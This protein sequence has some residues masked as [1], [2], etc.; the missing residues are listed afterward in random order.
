MKHPFRFEID[1]LVRIINF[2]GIRALSFPLLKASS[3]VPDME[4]MIGKITHRNYNLR[5]DGSDQNCYDVVL[6][7]NNVGSSGPCFIEVGEMIC[8]NELEKINGIEVA[9]W[10]ARHRKSCRGSY[11]KCRTQT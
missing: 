2:S 1:D 3:I 10:W 9:Y 5:D 6:W 7:V 11:Q 4:N 8:E